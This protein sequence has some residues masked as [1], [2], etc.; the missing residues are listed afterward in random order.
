[1]IDLQVVKSR[2]LLTPSSVSVVPTQATQLLKSSTGAIN[3]SVLTDPQVASFFGLE[4][5]PAS[6]D[7]LIVTSG[8]NAGQSFIVNSVGANFLNLDG[9]PVNDSPVFYALQRTILDPTKPI[10]LDIRG[11]NLTTTEE[12]RINDAPSPDVVVISQRQL[13]AQVPATVTAATQVRLIEIISS[14]PVRRDATKL[15][16]EFGNPSRPVEGIQKLVQLVLKILLTTPGRD[17]FD[18]D[19]GGGFL[20]QVGRNMTRNNVA[21][22]M[23]DLTVGI[24]QT[25]TQIISLQ[26]QDTSIPQDE[27]LLSLTLIDATFDEPSASIFVALRVQS[28]ARE[29]AV[30]R[31]FV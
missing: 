9:N 24:S 31:L 15:F 30:A 23:T 21:G 5:P 19:I 2:Q 4:I 17:I 13:L 14:L 8:L 22:L 16:F 10:V 27:R 7:S 6:G 1:M 25:Q 26:G 18:P 28:V 29:A 20:Q 12:V 3:N 11:S